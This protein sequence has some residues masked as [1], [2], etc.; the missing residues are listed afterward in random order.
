MRD[1]GLAGLGDL[2]SGEAVVVGDAAAR[3]A[4][5]G[6][7]GYMARMVPVPSES[8]L[9]TAVASTVKI[10]VAA[11][12]IWA[13]IVS[14]GVL[15]ATST[16]VS[17]S[18]DLDCGTRR[19]GLQAFLDGAGPAAIGAVAGSAVVLASEAAHSWQIIVLVAASI[20]LLIL[21][22]GVVAALVGAAVVGAIGR[23]AGLP[24][25]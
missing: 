17:R 25:S 22:R 9:T 3:E 5:A 15:R 14:V 19:C 16:A 6:C 21:P 8:N 10:C 12:V 24:L 7:A 4:P 2:G 18:A 23:V 11:W 1:G 13:A 20:W